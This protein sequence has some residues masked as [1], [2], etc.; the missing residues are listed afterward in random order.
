MK[1]SDII[2]WL[3]NWYGFYNVKYF[4]SK[5]PPKVK[6]KIGKGRKFRKWKKVADSLSHPE[7]AKPKITVTYK[8]RRYPNGLRQHLLHEMAHI[9]TCDETE[10]HGPK[11]KKEMRRLAKEGAFDDIW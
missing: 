2:T 7:I 10:H 8:H 9:A 6:I 1:D 3:Y 5:L 4:D 11:W